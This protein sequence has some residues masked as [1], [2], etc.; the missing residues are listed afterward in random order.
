MIAT[1]LTVI[2]MFT[3]MLLFIAE[4]VYESTNFYK[5]KY[6][7]LDKLKGNEKVDFVNTG[8]TFA[9]YGIDY[10]VC[11]VKGLNLALKPQSLEADFRM[12]KH[13][14]NRYN[15][16]TI[17]FIV[18]SDLAFAKK[19]YTEF[20]INDRYYKVFNSQEMDDYNP[21]KA[22]R[23]KYLPVLYSW[24]NFLRF[25]WDVQKDIE[26]DM[27][28]NENDREAVEADAYIRCRMWIDEF[29]LSNLQNGNQGDWFSDEFAY[30]T[31]IV[32]N[33]IIWCKERGYRPVLVNLPVSAELGAGFSSDFL[34]S[35]Y[36]RN[37]KK[38]VDKSKYGNVPFIDFQK[39]E[40]LSDYLLY[41]DSCRL[42]KIGREII[43][44]LLFREVER[45][46]NMT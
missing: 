18:I 21:L 15:H 19:G 3:I 34:D 7:E 41:L 17:V 8:S 24:K 45:R 16:G 43:T 4:K 27:E 36:Y 35:F 5:N 38:A 31:E 29:G 22:I 44:K 26:Y 12:L 1:G 13:F 39:N 33:M 20:G 28:V 25:H 23:A 14:E 40:K 46:S 2:I 37:I 11:G 9:F 30:T 42:N 32:S 6:G 10:N